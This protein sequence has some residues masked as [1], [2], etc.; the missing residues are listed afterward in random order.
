MNALRWVPSVVL[1]LAAGLLLGSP[2]ASADQSVPAE[3]TVD[4]QVPTCMKRATYR[5]IKK[6]MRYRRVKVLLNGQKPVWYTTLE[7]TPS[8]MYEG[9]G[10]TEGK[11][12]GLQFQRNLGA[13]LGSA[14][15][16]RK[17][18]NSCGTAP[19]CA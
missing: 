8:F 4:R 19:T 6:D 1:V 9:C 7:R 15:L 17:Y 11:G 5:A 10:W 12:V 2:G 18:L 13:P 14:R 16:T 3:A